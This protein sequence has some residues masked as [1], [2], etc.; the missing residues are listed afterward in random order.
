MSK[1]PDHD[2]SG[3][4]SS[5]SGQWSAQHGVGLVL[6]RDQCPA[7]GRHRG[8]DQSPFAPLRSYVIAGDDP[9]VRSGPSWAPRGRR[10]AR[11]RR[12]P[13]AGATVTPRQR[14]DPAVPDGTATGARE[15]AAAC[16]APAASSSGPCLSAPRAAPNSRSVSA[17]QAARATRSKGVEK[18]SAVCRRPSRTWCVQPTTPSSRPSSAARSRRRWSAA[19]RVPAQTGV[20][21]DHVPFGH[22]GRTHTGLE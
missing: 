15:A 2:R 22:D 10:S 16:A 3:A 18:D 8:Q 19:R 9:L 11:P 4:G 13:A 17:R 20:D 12:R 1:A 5:S 6:E 14:V 21:P 7:R